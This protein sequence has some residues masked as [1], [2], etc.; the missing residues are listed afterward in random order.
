M[1]E[2]KSIEDEVGAIMAQKTSDLVDPEE[3]PVSLKAKADA[4]DANAQYAFGE[5]LVHGDVTDMD[6]GIRYLR[7]SAVKG[8]LD[9]VDLLG[10]VYFLD[11]YGVE[12]DSESFKYAKQA[13]ENGYVHSQC[14]VAYLCALGRGT[15]KNAKAAREW[16]EKA[17]MANFNCQFALA[18]LADIQSGVPIEEAVES[19]ID[20]LLRV[21]AVMTQKELE[22]ELSSCGLS[23][24][25]VLDWHPGTAS[26]RPLTEE[27]ENQGVDDVC[28]VAGFRNEPDG[29]ETLCVK[30]VH[31]IRPFGSPNG[32]SGTG[33]RPDFRLPRRRDEVCLGSFEIPELAP[34]VAK[35]LKDYIRDRA[36]GRDRNVYETAGIP[37]TSFNDYKNGY[38]MPSRDVLIRVGFV[39]GLTLEEEERLLAAAGHAFVMSDLRDSICWKCFKRGICNPLD[40]N[41]VLYDK[42]CEPL[43]VG[44]VQRLI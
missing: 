35:L 22:R 26:S 15:A 31:R 28:V 33:K 12:D 14:R 11:Q 10:K 8:N 29:N 13:A 43:E 36:G 4:G 25:E 32:K 39:L 27:E 24:D 40:V 41:R 38:K 18:V 37:K 2:E 16:I 23:V 7:S 5:L 19:R 42:G 3:D 21:I 30:T 9:A 6:D 34:S 20:L 44:D 1:K 17:A